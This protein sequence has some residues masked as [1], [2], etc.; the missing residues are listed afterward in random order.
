[1]PKTREQI[2]CAEKNPKP[3]PPV[4]LRGRKKRAFEKKRKKKTRAACQS[5]PHPTDGTRVLHGVRHEQ[6]KRH[7]QKH[8]CERNRRSVGRCPEGS[9]RSNGNAG[10]KELTNKAPL[11]CVRIGDRRCNLDSRNEE[12]CFSA[13]LQTHAIFLFIVAERFCKSIDTQHHA[14]PALAF[15]FN[16][17]ISS[18][19]CHR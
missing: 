14:F 7:Q 1:M 19:P 10:K 5:K 12:L 8:L 6:T 13:L 15:R 4:K 11:Q 16:Q 9:K 18:R 3:L 2:T 17:E